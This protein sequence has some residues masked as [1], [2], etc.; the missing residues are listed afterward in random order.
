MKSTIKHEM[1]GMRCFG[2]E[3][4]RELVVIGWYSGILMYSDL[5]GDKD[6]ERRYG[7]G[8]M[9]PSVKEFH[10]YAC[11]SLMTCRTVMGSLGTLG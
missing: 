3:Q 5:Y 1:E 11:T 9:S 10:T 2:R 6:V 7:E 4:F 8:M